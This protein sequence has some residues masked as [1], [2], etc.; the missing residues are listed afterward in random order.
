MLMRRV[1]QACTPTQIRQ[2]QSIEDEL[3]AR[4][5]ANDYGGVLQ[6]NRRF[7]LAL[8]NIAANPEALAIIDR[9]WLLIAALWQ[10]VGYAPDRYDG[11][12]SDHGHL[13]RSLSQGD[14]DAAGTL[15]GAHVIK[16][17]Y[18]MLERMSAQTT[19]RNEAAA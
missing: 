12:V 15:M 16:A 2:N 19:A 9:H 6:A 5:A 18:E 1:A 7:H 14:V 4:L 8:N 10:R 3:E 11:V 13:L 17:K